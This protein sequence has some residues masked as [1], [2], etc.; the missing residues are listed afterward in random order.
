MMEERNEA[1]E[2]EV[3]R[4]LLYQYR[5]EWSEALRGFLKYMGNDFNG[6]PSRRN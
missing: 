2:D 3:V 5:S 1:F 4:E 6:G